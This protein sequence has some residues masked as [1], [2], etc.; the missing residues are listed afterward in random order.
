MRLC[1]CCSGH[2]MR[3]ERPMGAAVLVRQSCMCGLA[4][5]GSLAMRQPLCLYRELCYCF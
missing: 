2:R 5:A 3:I 1:L 4:Y